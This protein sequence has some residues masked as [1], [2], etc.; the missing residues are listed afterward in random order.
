MIHAIPLIHGDS[1]S[2]ESVVLTTAPAKSM[3]GC[4]CIATHH[5]CSVAI[6]THS[7]HRRFLFKR[8]V[9][10]SINTSLGRT[11]G[12]WAELCEQ[13]NE[14]MRENQSVVNLVVACQ[15]VFQAA[16]NNI[17]ILGEEHPNK[18]RFPCHT[19]QGSG[20]DGSA[21]RPFLDLIE[22]MKPISVEIEVT[23]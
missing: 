3:L 22:F 18:G 17:E 9:F 4:A 8:T 16:E 21:S 5:F 11:E 2:R 15:S 14:E 6:L 12:G 7:S 23:S 1:S 19:S 10:D 13:Y 20:R